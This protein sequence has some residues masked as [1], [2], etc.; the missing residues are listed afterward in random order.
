M[1]L[2]IRGRYGFIDPGVFIMCVRSRRVIP[3]DYLVRYYASQRAEVTRT[4]VVGRTTPAHGYGSL[5][6]TIRDF[7]PPA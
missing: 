4:P 3:R 2:L 5:V 1:R 7:R 6:P